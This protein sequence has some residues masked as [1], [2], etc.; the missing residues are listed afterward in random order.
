[1]SSKPE[2]VYQAKHYSQGRMDH[3]NGV[4]V[5][6]NPHISTVAFIWWRK[7]W[8]DAKEE[9]PAATCRE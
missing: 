9:A 3:M 1:M 8:L 4:K 2:T 7:G 5:T 6:E